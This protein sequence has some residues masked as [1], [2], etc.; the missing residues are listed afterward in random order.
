MNR[1]NKDMLGAGLVGFL[2]GKG[3]VRPIRSLLWLGFVALAVGALGVALAAR[4]WPE[5]L[6]VVAVVAFVRHHR[7]Q[8]PSLPASPPPQGTPRRALPPTRPTWDDL[9][10]AFA[11]GYN[12]GQRE[13]RKVE[14]SWGRSVPAFDPDDPDA[15]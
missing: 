11:E 4:Y 15:F 12:R 10:V 9:D 1:S 5:A 6:V 2:A 3:H 7:R 13:A 14:R 8:R